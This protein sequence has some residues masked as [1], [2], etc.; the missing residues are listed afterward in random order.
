MNANRVDELN[1]NNRGPATSDKPITYADPLL[2][3]T[4]DM[5]LRMDASQYTMATVSKAS[6]TKI[7]SW[8]FDEPSEKDQLTE[9]DEDGNYQENKYTY[10]MSF[11][12]DESITGSPSATFTS[13]S[14][15]HEEDDPP[16]APGT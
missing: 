13:L 7:E 6:Q 14:P 1:T 16:L 4:N 3:K 12:N 5:T 11:N 10:S 8:V 15:T 2:K 9:D